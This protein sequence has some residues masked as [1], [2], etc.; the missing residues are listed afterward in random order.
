MNGFAVDQFCRDRT[1]YYRFSSNQVTV[2]CV[3][4]HAARQISLEAILVMSDNLVV[5]S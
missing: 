4:I 3:L 2:T 5:V 1:N